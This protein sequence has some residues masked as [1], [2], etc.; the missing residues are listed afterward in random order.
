MTTLYEKYCG[1]ISGVADVYPHLAADSK[2]SE[3]T[4]GPIVAHGIELSSRYDKVFELFEMLRF[5]EICHK[6]RI[7]HL[8]KSVNY[9]SKGCSVNIEP[10][11]LVKKQ[12]G[13]FLAILE[14]AKS[15]FENF[16]LLED[17]YCGTYKTIDDRIDDNAEYMRGH[18]DG[19]LV[20]HEEGIG[21]GHDIG[22]KRGVQIGK[23]EVAEQVRVLLVASREATKKGMS[24]DGVILFNIDLEYVESL[25]P[26]VG[27]KS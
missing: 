15:S 6:E 17:D 12:D 25:V 24:P 21:T 10:V 13:P 23:Y 27:P 19:R 3:Y 7:S 20:G 26:P 2:H 11:S 16:W 14:V 5:A 1:N 4:G 9:D 18:E 22:F 8:V